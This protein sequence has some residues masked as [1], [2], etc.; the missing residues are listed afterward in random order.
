VHLRPCH[1]VQNHAVNDVREQGG[2]LTADTDLLEQEG[3]VVEDAVDA[4]GLLPELST[5]TDEGAASIFR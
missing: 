4:D 2:F 3:G 5:R 1:D